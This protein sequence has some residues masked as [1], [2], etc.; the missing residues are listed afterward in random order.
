MPS[1]LTRSDPQEPL[2]I[3]VEVE[4]IEK[5]RGK[6]EI[7]EAQPA[8]IQQRRQQGSRKLGIPVPKQRAPHQLVW[9]AVTTKLI[10]LAAQSI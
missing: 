1:P 4:E 3:D 6:I 2:K 8:A 7:Q 9:T 5:T 10:A